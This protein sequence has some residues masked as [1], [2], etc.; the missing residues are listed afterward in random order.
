MRENCSTLQVG[1]GTP[2]HFYFPIRTV[3]CQNK[4]VALNSGGLCHRTRM[5]GP[6]AHTGAASQ[7]CADL[8]R[9]LCGVRLCS[10]QTTVG[11]VGL[12]VC[13][14]PGLRAP[15]S[16]S[17]QHA[18]SPSYPCPQTEDVGGFLVVKDNAEEVTFLKSTYI[19]YRILCSQ[20]CTKKLETNTEK[21]KLVLPGGPCL[22]IHLLSFS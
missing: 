22:P 2:F 6:R 11:R 9:E 8:T 16:S 12:S 10:Q 21:V 3:L 4:R 7:T 13:R 18:R 5:G 17:S 19:E 14:V 1:T 15:Y 20:K